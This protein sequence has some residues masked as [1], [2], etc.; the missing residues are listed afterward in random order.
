MGGTSARSAVLK[1]GK[2]PARIRFQTFLPVNS[3][4]LGDVMKTSDHVHMLARP[5]YLWPPKVN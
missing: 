1:V 4:G 3:L 5:V 2:T